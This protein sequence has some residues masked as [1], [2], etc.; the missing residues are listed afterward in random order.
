[1]IL[2]LAAGALLILIGATLLPVPGGAQQPYVLGP[3]DVVEVSVY[4]NDDLSRV[5]T[6]R[7]DGMISLPL[8]GEI[9]AAG[10]T[11]EQLRERLVPLYA[12]FIRNP[13]V[14]VIV[15]EFRRVRV[16]VLGQVMRPGVHE[17]RLGSSVLDA[18]ASAGGLTEA[19]GLGELR[20]SR[21]QAPPVVIDLERLLLRG[22]VA[23]NQRLETGDTLVVP[24]DLTA[25]VYVLGEVAR[26]GVIPLRGPMTVVQALGLVGGPTRRAMLGRAYVI[27]RGVESAA[28]PLPLATVT[29][30]RQ[31]GPPLKLIPVDLHK[32]LRAGDVARDLLLQR[33]DVLYVP[34]NPLALENIVLILT[35]I[36]DL[37]SLLR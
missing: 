18:L 9:R 25:R 6:V 1:M 3:E 22:E 4:G 37:R 8:V 2:R 29:V 28:E 16:T 34:D 15:R 21:G 31:A 33:G 36:A 20:L 12:R 35:G 7:P 23:L 32:I 17:L 19:A 27:R 26:P 5:V 13:Q 11:P 10:L 24:E 30:A 14:A